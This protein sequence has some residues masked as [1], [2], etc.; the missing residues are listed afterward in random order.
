MVGETGFNP[1]F[2]KA[3][4]FYSQDFLSK[5]LKRLKRLFKQE[6]P[7]TDLEAF[8]TSGDLFFDTEALQYYL[9]NSSVPDEQ[10]SILP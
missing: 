10:L 1:L 2:Y 7:E 8:L 3:S 5:E 9:E 6:Y 4:E